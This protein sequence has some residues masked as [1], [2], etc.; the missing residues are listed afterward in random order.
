MRT[1]RVAALALVATACGAPPVPTPP[2]TPS[3]PAAAPAAAPAPAR[4]GVAV[5]AGDPHSRV[6][7]APHTGTI[8]TVALEPHGTAAVTADTQGGVRLWPMLDGSAEPIVVDLPLPRELALAV[9]DRGFTVGLIDPGREL[10]IARLDHAGRLTSRVNLGGDPSCRQIEMTDAGLLAWRD[11]QT[12][13]LFDDD[14]KPTA[15][16][17]TEPGQRLTGLATGGGRAIAILELVDKG[18]TARRARWIE[19]APK[20]AWGA[21]ASPEGAVGDD[22]VLSPDGEVLATTSETPSTLE[23]VDTRTS[24]KLATT[25]LN[26]GVTLAFAS[27][28]ELGMFGADGTPSWIPVPTRSTPTVEES[29]PRPASETPPPDPGDRVPVPMA[30]ASGRIVLGG[31][32]DLELVTPL[33]TQYLGYAISSIEGAVPGSDGSLL[34]ASGDELALLDRDLVA[35]SAIPFHPAA[36]LDV[37]AMSWLGGNDWLISV[38]SQVNGDVLPS[39]VDLA[40]GSSKRATLPGHG[41]GFVDYEPGTQILSIATDKSVEIEHFNAETQVLEKV[42]SL[43]ITLYDPVLTMPTAPD[44]A[45][46]SELVSAATRDHIKLSWIPDRAHPDRASATISVDGSFI[47]SDPVGRVYVWRAKPDN[48]Y[49]L[50]IFDQGKRF[51]SLPFATP[52]EIKPDRAGQ[53]I[54]TSGSSGI[55]LIDLDGKVR[56]TTPLLGARSL[57]WLSD[58]SL[59]AIYQTGVVRLDPATGAIAAQRCGWKFGLHD[60]PSPATGEIESMCARN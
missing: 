36:Q 13:T 4:S 42:A 49:M 34:V 37:A 20:L 47:A 38:I 60:K 21:W 3:A 55:T 6:V 11:D 46:G 33:K 58:G 24:T 1:D 28:T 43:P 54:A 17:P 48:T 25:P 50:D 51:A 14:G 35:K 26:R 19:L 9:R 2:A 29:K 59:A 10:A 45:H 41:V 53:H 27:T 23:I 15:R 8:T 39:I 18:A 57:E 22:P 12:L 30:A 40:T 56:W 7:N 44:R 31:G 52:V 32:A 16:L 5:V